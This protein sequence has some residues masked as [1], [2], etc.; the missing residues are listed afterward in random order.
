MA[1]PLVRKETPTEYFR[2]LVE[3]AIQRSISVR[4]R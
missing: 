2:E 1:E 3:S 4:A